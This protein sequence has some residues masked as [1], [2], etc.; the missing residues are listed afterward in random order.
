MPR[1]EVDP[2]RSGHV[3]RTPPLASAF[4]YQAVRQALTYQAVRQALTYQ[5][6]RQ[7][8]TY[9]AVRQALTHQAVRQ[10]LTYQA[11]RQRLPTIQCATG[12]AS[13]LTNT[14]SMLVSGRCGECTMRPL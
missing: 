12:A 10:A 8:L 4:A 2:G 9:Q 13:G 7:A 6:V 11:V 3:P 14:A 1:V 5:A